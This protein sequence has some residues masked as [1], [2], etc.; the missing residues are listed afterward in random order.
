[1]NIGLP[2]IDIIFKSLAT[3]SIER[4]AK[5]IALLIIKD[6]TDQTFDF[7]EY[8]KI[9]EIEMSKFTVSN[10]NYIRE[11]FSGNPSKIIVARMDVAGTLSDLL[12]LIKA[13][14]FNWV[15]LAEG[16]DT[17]QN[18]L[19]TWIKSTNASYDKVYKAIVFNATIPD[20]MHIINFENS[21]VKQVGKNEITGEK[22]LARLLGLFAGLPFTE[23]ATYFVLK[24][25][26]SV[27]QVD[28]A[29]ASVNSGKL[30]LI[31]DDEVV[32]IARGVNSLVTTDIPLSDDM[33]KITIVEAMDLIKTDIKTLFKNNYVGKYKNV[34]DNQVLF[35]SAINSYFR[36]LANE[37]IL[38]IN[39]NNQA[40]VDIE[41]QRLA[42]IGIGKSE[43]Q[44]W[45]DL[46]VKINTFRSNIYL[47]GDIKILDAMEDLHFNI[48]M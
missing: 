44:E 3:S 25:L 32:R 10:A 17:E 26:E 29:E 13:K 14:H 48:N 4:S 9:D 19:A 36:I 28:D 8:K 5:G 18:E 30:V 1:M 23:S 38:D 34:Y 16:T 2:S 11:C 43:A 7:V 45:D 47:A 21:K 37:D 35:I 20:D 12:I 22:Y 46:T 40:S 33:K 39:S 15:A 6:D 24:D 42:W 27:T 31:N 41:A